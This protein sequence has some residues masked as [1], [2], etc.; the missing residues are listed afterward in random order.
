MSRARRAAPPRP[1]PRPILADVERPPAEGR[2]AVTVAV[3]EEEGDVR[4]EGGEVVVVEG[5]VRRV[6]VRA[7]EVV[8]KVEVSV[9]TEVDDGVGGRDGGGG[10]EVLGCG[11]GLESEEGGGGGGNED[12]GSGVGSGVIFGSEDDDGGAELGG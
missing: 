1:A 11:G 2:G 6:V 5:E 4:V 12:D 9:G 3:G 10:S 7:V 8:G